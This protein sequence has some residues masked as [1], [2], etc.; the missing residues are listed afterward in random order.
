[1]LFMFTLHVICSFIIQHARGTPVDEPQP[2]KTISSVGTR[3]EEE[4][5]VDE[6]EE[7]EVEG[8]DGVDDELLLLFVLLFLLLLHMIV[9]AATITT[10][11][12]YII[13]LD[14]DCNE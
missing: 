6:E 1:M 5:E 2:R 3:E 9:V 7:G 14:D 12:I 13:H 4:D 8:K 10:G 11:N